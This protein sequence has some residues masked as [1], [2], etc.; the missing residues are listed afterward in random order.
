MLDVKSARDASLEARQLPI[1]C[2]IYSL[3]YFKD[4]VST[5]N[6]GLHHNH[7]VSGLSQYIP[8]VRGLYEIRYL[9]R[10]VHS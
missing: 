1:R 2:R 8:A 4:F 3:E 7:R 9:S 5:S 10:S 6:G